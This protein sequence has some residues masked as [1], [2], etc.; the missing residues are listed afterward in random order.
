MSMYVHLEQNP[1]F[2]GE[3]TPI[4]VFMA[5]TI[6]AYLNSIGARKIVIWDELERLPWKSKVNILYKTTGKDPDWGKDPLQFAVEVFKTRDLLA[7]RKPERVVGPLFNEETE[8]NE[9]LKTTSMEP[10]WYKKITKEWVIN[11]K[12]RFRILMIHFANLFDLHESDHLLASEAG[13]I[14]DDQAET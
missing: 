3:L 4:V 2:K 6:E 11:S 12:E 9:Y 7:H 13:L 10:E 1:D 14:L 8:A 5:F